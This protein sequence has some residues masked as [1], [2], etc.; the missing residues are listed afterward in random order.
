MYEGYLPQ[1]SFALTTKGSSSLYEHQFM[2]G[3]IFVFGSE[4]AGLPPDIREQ[5]PASQRLRIPMQ[6]NQRSLNLSNA[7]AVTLYEAW[8]QIQFMPTYPT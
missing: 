7:A 5:F 8:R 3:D 2:R 1:R 4:T 6:A